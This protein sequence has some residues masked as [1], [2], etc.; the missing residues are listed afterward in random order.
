MKILTFGLTSYPT[1]VMVM[2][3]HQK[4]SGNVQVELALTNIVLFLYAMAIS[5][6]SSVSQMYTQLAKLKIPTT[7]RK[8]M[9]RNNG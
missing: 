9:I 3:P 1:V 7:N 5:S 4:H 6:P 2:S 8:L